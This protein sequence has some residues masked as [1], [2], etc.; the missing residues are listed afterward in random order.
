MKN[1]QFKNLFEKSFSFPSFSQYWLQVIKRKD[2][3]EKKEY[4]F[5][6]KQ[7][8]ETYD[9]IKEI[10]KIV[11][12]QL[13]KKKDI[14]IME[15]ISKKSVDFFINSGEKNVAINEIVE[16]LL[17][18]LIC[19]V[20]DG[21][22]FSYNGIL[23]EEIGS[24]DINI[25]IN[26]NFPKTITNTLSPAYGK[27]IF[28]RLKTTP[29]IQ[30]HMEEF[31]K[32]DERF[33]CFENGVFDLETNCLLPHA[34]QYHCTN[35][36]AAN[37]IDNPVNGE[38]FNNYLTH[39][40]QNNLA[41]KQRILEFL[42]YCLSSSNRAKAL[43]LL[44]GPGNTGKSTFARIIQ[45]LLGDC[46]YTAFNLKELGNRT[47]TTGTFF[48]KLAA[49]DTDLS[50]ETYN[51][52]VAKLLK[53]LS[54]GDAIKGEFK[55]KNPFTFRNTCK[56]ILAT[57]FIPSFQEEDEALE[58]RWLKLPFLSPISREEMMTDLLEKLLEEKDYIIFKSIEA[59]TTLIQND[60]KFTDIGDL[61]HYNPACNVESRKF[62][63]AS[64][65]SDFLLSTCELDSTYN[66]KITT[67]E[68]YDIYKKFYK[69]R[70]YPEA[71]VPKT[72]F[73]KMVFEYYEGSVKPSSHA[74]ARGFSG[75]ALKKRS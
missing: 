34:P 74:K 43:F 61:E 44:I 37:Y 72:T 58:R 40:T 30:I 1:I 60:Y 49:F 21:V 42:G 2:F 13:K 63:I 38:L 27:E 3:E 36:I 25:Y 5:E 64:S 70:E 57:N 39:L 71:S 23:W 18:D 9:I 16:N 17:N 41:L 55:N 6:L 14:E 68:L 11:E 20:I 35:M 32:N 22:L 53:Q 48:N 75:I 67:T 47:W 7:K 24:S 33:I 59:L 10:Q 15:N 12:F 73:S 31:K 45:S 28:E 51:D 56:I 50:A 26:K 19:A 52:N 65:V 54:G 4:F 8:C 69:T 66:T 29:E 46:N 62:K